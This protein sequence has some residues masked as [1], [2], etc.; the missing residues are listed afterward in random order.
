MLHAVI[1]LF[2][3]VAGWLCRIP[4]LAWLLPVCVTLFA[5]AV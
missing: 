5:E 4:A 1:T 2:F 3:A